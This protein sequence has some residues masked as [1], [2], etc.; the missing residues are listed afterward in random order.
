MIG[1]IGGPPRLLVGG[2]SHPTGASPYCQER[3]GQVSLTVEWRGP[4]IE[5]P[6]FFRRS[7]GSDS[8]LDHALLTLVARELPRP[9]ARRV[10]PVR[11]RCSRSGGG[12][13]PGTGRR[14]GN[15]SR[16][17]GGH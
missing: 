12:R 8:T 15:G 3:S 13:S 9:G 5:E 16:D 2:R 6:P 17:R 14:G 10:D 1:G 7:G 11:A 4:H